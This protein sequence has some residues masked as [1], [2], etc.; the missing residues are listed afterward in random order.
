ML[1]GPLIN[2]LISL[3]GIIV[4]LYLLLVGEMR[5]L[6]NPDVFR[7]W[8]A[9]GVLIFIL[10]LPAYN[11]TRFV[12]ERSPEFDSTEFLNQ[13][14]SDYSTS[15]WKTLFAFLL[16]YWPINKFMNRKGLYVID[17]Y[18]RPYWY[19]DEARRRMKWFDV[20]INIFLFLVVFVFGLYG[21]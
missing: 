8:L 11:D 17:T 1:G 10:S 4:P 19:H 21:P 12:L 14:M 5:D 15:S 2:I 7:L 20:L 6:N 18:K 9:A 16:A 3:F 13:N